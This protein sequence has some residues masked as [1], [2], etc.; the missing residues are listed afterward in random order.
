MGVVVKARER[1]GRRKGR[2]GRRER[3]EGRRNRRVE[4]GIIEV[5]SMLLWS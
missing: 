3:N 1:A 4:G 5:I 2:E